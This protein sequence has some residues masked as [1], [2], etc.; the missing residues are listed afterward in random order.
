MIGIADRTTMKECVDG[1][2]K[3]HLFRHSL[4]LESSLT[5]CQLHRLVNI[6]GQGFDMPE[7]MS[8]TI[9]SFPIY[10]RKLVLCESV[11][12]MST[13]DDIPPTIRPTA[14]I[15]DVCFLYLSL[16]DAVCW[17]IPAK[18]EHFPILQSVREITGRNIPVW[19]WRA[20]GAYPALY[21]F[22]PEKYGG[23]GDVAK[24]AR[25]VAEATGRDVEEVI[26]EVDPYFSLSLLLLDADKQ[27]DDKHEAG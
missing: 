18:Y 26:K 9:K 19:N 3:Y 2:G 7:L 27:L 13:G 23:L 11:R 17:L 25:D 1:C 21:L 8:I 5:Q 10:Y 24:K 15:T 4:F 16:L 6:G 12:S 14:V 22:S 20:S